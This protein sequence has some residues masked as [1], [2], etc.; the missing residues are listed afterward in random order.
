MLERRESSRR[1]TSRIPAASTSARR[2]CRSTRSSRGAPDLAAPRAGG[3]RLEA[4]VARDRETQ[5]ARLRTLV[6][7]REFRD[8]L[9]VASPDLDEAF[10]TWIADPES[11]RGQRVERALV[12]YVSRA[13]GRATPFGLF[14]GTSVGRIGDSTDLVLDAS[15]RSVRHSRLD[16]DYLFALAGALTM[17]PVRRSGFTWKPNSSLYES[18]GHLRY[19]ESR[20]AGEERTYHLVAVESSSALTATLSRAASGATAADLAAALVDA[21]V[22]RAEADEF[23][24]D[25]VDSQI[26]VPGARARRHRR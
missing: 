13:A 9:F 21:D 18:A 1:A 14:A 19:V 10:D 7:S 11:E 22:S 6:S 4:A 8:A 12:K 26:L 5:R 23:I 16:M 15:A 25:L 20:L 17:D 3:D 2:C 24:A